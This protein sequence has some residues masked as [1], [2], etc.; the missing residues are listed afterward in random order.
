M[1]IDWGWASHN[2]EQRPY[3]ERIVQKV[4]SLFAGSYLNRKG[5][6][7]AMVNSVLIESPTG[8]GKTI[9]GLI[10]A[11]YLQTTF[12]FRVGWVA[13]RRNLLAQVATENAVRGFDVEMATI[14]MFDREP[15]K[16]D[17]LVVDEAQHDAALSMA[18][19]HCRIKPRKIL[20]LSA[21]PYRTDRVKLCFQKVITDAGIHQLIQEGYLSRYHHY[22]IPQYSPQSVA[23]SYCSEQ[24]RW[25]KSL[26]FFHR[27]EQCETCRDILT[28][29]GIV[30][31][32]VT[33]K[34]NR[35]R[36]IRDFATGKVQVLISM[37]ILAEGFD[38]PS[39]KTVFCRP[40][41]R[42]CTVQM[43]GRVFRKHPDLP[44]KQIVQC[45]NTR[46]PFPRTATPEEQYT[47]MDDGWRTLK[48]N[49]R[50]AS[51]SAN[52]LRA[53]ARCPTQLPAAVRRKVGRRR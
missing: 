53:V 19:I 3:Q 45:K 24:D 43:G 20:G 29:E 16:V 44:K 49:S 8:S 10:V 50:L 47:W 25:G 17:L 5:E 38:C 26:L 28:R 46:H 31:E 34:T 40:S 11:K 41:G 2:V 36:Q 48:L 21:T 52:A 12:G 13:M 42:S 1:L 6:R 51:I 30:V 33:G 7:K 14:S 15:P 35:G 18:N 4:L 39:L 32:V 37:S 9:M 23:E 22:T 27:Q